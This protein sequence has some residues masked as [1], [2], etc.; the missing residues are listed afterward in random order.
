MRFL[1][2]IFTFH[3]FL[4]FR[5]MT[6]LY[7]EMQRKLTFFYHLPVSRVNRNIVNYWKQKSVF[8]FFDSEH[9]AGVGEEEYKACDQVETRKY[10]RHQNRLFQNVSVKVPTYVSKS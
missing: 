8:F 1:Q 5:E 2:Q 3:T 9:H 6:K 4:K 10:F 7:R